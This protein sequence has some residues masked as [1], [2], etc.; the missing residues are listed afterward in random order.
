MEKGNELHDLVDFTYNLNHKLNGITFKEEKN[1]IEYEGYINKMFEPTYPK[2]IG[3]FELVIYNL[4]K[5]K[6]FNE[7]DGLLELIEELSDGFSSRYLNINKLVNDYDLDFKN[8]DRII[9][10]KNCVIHPDWRD[11]GLYKEL[12]KSIYLTQFIDNSLFIVNSSPIQ[13]DDDFNIYFK[14]FPIDITDGKG[15]I[16]PTSLG[17]YF[18]LDKLP[19]PDEMNDYKLYAKML[20]LNLNQFENANYFYQ[21]DENKLLDL[22]KN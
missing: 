12:I 20:K 21:D 3:Y 1:E 4:N 10:L 11:K 2:T 15:N 17:E 22:F 9:F 19:K 16:I 8:K 13:N 7:S 5:S 14:E 18:H 6:K